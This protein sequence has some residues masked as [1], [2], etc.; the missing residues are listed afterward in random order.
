M[1]AD[2]NAVT[3]IVASLISLA[4]LWWLVFFAFRDYRVDAFRERLFR[5]REDLFLFAANG[6][7]PFEHP[8][9]RMLRST[10]NGMI[11]YAER[12]SLAWL[13]SLAV[14]FKHSDCREAEKLFHEQ[15]LEANRTLTLHAKKRLILFRRDLHWALTTHVLTSPLIIVASS[16]F[17]LLA[18]IRVARD[19]AKEKFQRWIEPTLSRVDSVALL[20]GDQSMRRAA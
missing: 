6:G 17:L 7:I 5:L 10:I 12:I 4:A 14:A 18:L 9:Y 11:R 1:I 15:W 3:N 20:E 8:A 19:H 13:L 16:P 2:P